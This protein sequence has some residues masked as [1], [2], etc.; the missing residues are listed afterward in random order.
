MARNSSMSFCWTLWKHL[1]RYPSQ[2]RLQQIVD[3]CGVRRSMMEW[4]SSLLEHGT[5]QV[6]H[7]AKPYP[8]QMLRS[9]STRHRTRLIHIL[10]LHQRP[11]YQRQV[12]CKAVCRPFARPFAVTLNRKL[13]WNEQVSATCYRANGALAFLRMNM[14]SNTLKHGATSPWSGLS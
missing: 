10:H 7:K 9:E 4:T 2:R 6:I 3:K 8:P 14:D 1:I 13:S 12:N 11:S 5:Q